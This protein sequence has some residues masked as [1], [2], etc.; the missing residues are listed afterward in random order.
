MSIKLVKRHLGVGMVE[1]KVSPT[2]IN[3]LPSGGRID[4][5]KLLEFTFNGKRYQAYQG[6]TLASALLANR[7]G[8]VGRSFKYHRPR[9]IVAAGS[10]EPNA[11]LQL[12]NGVGSTPNLRATQVELYYGL[13]ASSVNCWPS[14]DFDLGSFTGLFSRI[15]PAGFYYKTFMWPQNLW[16]WYLR[17][18]A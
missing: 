2:Q 17:R 6:D 7:V 10:E 3:R 16:M 12:E 15:L 11:I 14:V 8:V 13:R 1:R 18:L 9:G 4:R 5:G